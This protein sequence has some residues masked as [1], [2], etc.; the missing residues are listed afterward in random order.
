MA[1]M[2][3]STNASRSAGVSVS[4]TSGS[5]FDVRMIHETWYPGWQV[6][7][8]L[9][10]LQITCE[11]VY[12][13]GFLIERLLLEP[14]PVPEAA[15]LDP[16]EYEQLTREPRGFIAFRLVPRQDGLS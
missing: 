9:A 10:P 4:S 2:S 7:Y 1:N 8:W 5:Y 6:H 14:W 12:R 13:A 15:A 11:E 16:A 3:C